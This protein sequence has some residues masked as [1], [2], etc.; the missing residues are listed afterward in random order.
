MP[1]KQELSLPAANLVYGRD[2]D[3]KCSVTKIRK[4]RGIPND[5]FTSRLIFRLHEA[6]K[7]ERR[8]VYSDQAELG[9]SGK[10]IPLLAQLLRRMGHF[11]IKNFTK[12]AAKLRIILNVPIL[13]LNRNNSGIH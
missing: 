11:P 6:A 4:G 2:G 10:Q 9:F 8:H 3:K 12:I 5:R 1:T 13:L 7:S